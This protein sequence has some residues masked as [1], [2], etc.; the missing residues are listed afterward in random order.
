MR[1]ASDRIKAILKSPS[2]Q[3]MI[4]YI[5]P[6]YSEDAIALWLLEVI[7]RELD[8]MESWIKDYARQVVPQAATW[9]LDYFEEE[10]DLPV[11]PNLPVEQ[12]REIILTTII[13]RAPMNPAKLARAAAAV[14]GFESRIEENTGKNKFTLYVS[15]LPA[16]VDEKRLR[17]AINK[18]KPAHIIF[19]V[20]Y[21]Q[22]V[23]TEAYFAAVG[24]VYREVTIHEV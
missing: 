19:D 9:G 24:Q 2:G 20:L 14:T 1:Q 6:I 5:S 11:G 12:R 18:S 15:G 22:T 21:E 7:G 23:L 10:Y 17:A 13:T 4:D 3:K 8:E 16:Q